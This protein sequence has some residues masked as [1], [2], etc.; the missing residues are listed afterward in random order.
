MSDV[1]AHA[2]DCGCGARAHE[3][4]ERAVDNTSWDGPAAMSSCVK[5]STPGS[6]FGSICAGRKSGPAEQEGSWALPHHKHPGDPPNAAGVRNALARLSQTQGLT[7]EAAA[8]S[9]LE[10]HMSSIQNQSS[11]SARPPRDNL[12]RG[13]FPFELRDDEADAMPTM[14]G[15]FAV[16]NRWTEIDS[17]WEGRFMEQIAP[18]AFSKT[19]NENR[20][21]VKVLFQHGKDPQVGS[22]ILGPIADLREDGTGAYYEVPLYDTSYN[23]DLMPGLKDGQYGASFRFRVV[24]EDVNNKPE[25]SEGNPEGIPERTIREIALS[26][27]GPVTFPAYGDATAGVR[28][29]TD[30]FI[31]QA[32]GMEPGRLER[33]LSHYVQHEG[34]APHSHSAEAPHSVAGAAKITPRTSLTVIRNPNRGGA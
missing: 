24:R 17:L 27:F 11:S 28:S 30:D 15:H 23:R 14:F 9:H 29:L 18:G 19:F 31:L 13:V 32:L 21:N 20:D 25:R 22:K 3:S 6:C 16:F 8:R 2:S 33:L 34:H 5:S 26:E 10:A 7:N 12:V 4:G 1:H